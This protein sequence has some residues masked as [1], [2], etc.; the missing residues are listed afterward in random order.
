[1][2]KK[3]IPTIVICFGIF[4]LWNQFVTGPQQAHE[5][6]EAEAAQA[7]AD[8]NKAKASPAPAM[9]NAATAPQ[10]NPLAATA[11]SAAPVAAAVTE[12][13]ERPQFHAVLTSQD[14]ALSSFQLLNPQYTEMVGSDGKK[15]TRQIDL[16]KNDERTFELGFVESNISPPIGAIWQRAVGG[17]PTY[18]F[19]MGG[20]HLTKEYLFDTD[21]Y[22]FIV[23]LTVENTT[24]AA[25]NGKLLAR[26]NG[27]HDPNVKQG[28]MFSARLSMTEGGCLTH[29]AGWF[30]DDSYDHSDLPSLL[31]K[32]LVSEHQARWVSID[33]KYFVTALAVPVGAE[34][35]HCSVNAQPDGLIEAVME[36]PSRAFA[37]GQKSVYRLRGYAGPKVR[38][39][40]RAVALDGQSIALNRAITYN[41]FGEW[42]AP[43]MLAVLR[44]IH[45]VVP[46]WGLAVVC[47]TILLKLVT[48]W[49][50]ASGMRSMKAMAK[51]KPEMDKLREK[52]GEDKNRLNTEV[53]AL[54]K[55][56]NIN[57][58]GGCLP[59]LIQMPIYIAFYSMLGNSIELFHSGFYFWI[60]DLT[61]P[62]PYYVLAVATGAITF[63][64][65][66]LSPT[67]PDPQQKTMMYIMPVMFTGISLFLPAGLTLYMFT[68]ALLTML[69][70]WW[71]NRHDLRALAEKKSAAKTTKK[72]KA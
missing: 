40:L 6:A 21:G 45:V 59:M 53:M 49:P 12:T 4:L 16:V 71:M 30:S 26:L 67:P 47:F 37:P 70:Q 72:V 68:N 7:R 20:L 50:T 51:L 8:A 11:P 13:I 29:S 2:D 41:W 66:S 22:G 25:I 58:L 39:E 48:W 24:A 33:E 57:P 32:P 56:H 62:D 35:N 44:A 43:S 3:F 5:K 34:I 28:G 9:V 63:L 42:I 10:V 27:Y 19:D 54:Y 18:T 31:K 65:Q 15:I 55:K 36:L 60:H 61:A 64:Q 23:Q 1:M 17:V 38:N 14:A 69:Q 46:N 52:F